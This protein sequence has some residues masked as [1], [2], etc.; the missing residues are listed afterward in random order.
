MSFYVQKL[1]ASVRL[2]QPNRDPRDGWLQLL[3]RLP[4]EP[5]PETILDLLN[6]GRSVVPFI[7]AEDTGVL[8]F[9]RLNIEWVSIGAG[10]APELV[11]PPGSAP[12]HE[13][14]AELRFLDESRVDAVIQWQTHEEGVRLSD[15]LNSSPD[16]VAVKT[17]LGTLLVNKQRV[18]EIR[19][20]ESTSRALGS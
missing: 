3:P 14:R 9:T 5:R 13:Q 16:F 19:I 7:Q 2:S 18:R 20:I 4:Q 15:F 12:T 11:L 1:R 10:T 17:R 6:S 8:L